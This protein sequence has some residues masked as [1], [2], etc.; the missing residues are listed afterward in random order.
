MFSLC[1]LVASAP[2]SPKR[3]TL[4]GISMPLE[5][6]NVE[7]PFRRPTPSTS[8]V[9]TSNADAPEFCAIPAAPTKSF[10]SGAPRGVADYYYFFFRI[11]SASFKLCPPAHF[12]T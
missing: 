1:T 4:Y 2:F 9:K 11:P 6:C 3:R 12:S 5:Q 8:W 10:F 7:A